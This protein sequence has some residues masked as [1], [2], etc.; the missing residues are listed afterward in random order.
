MCLGGGGR[1]PHPW[2]FWTTS[3]TSTLRSGKS[4]IGGKFRCAKRSVRSSG[5]PPNL[6]P[7]GGVVG[8]VIPDASKPPFS[9]ISRFSGKVGK[10]AFSMPP[11]RAASKK[12]SQGG[13]PPTLNRSFPGLGHFPYPTPIFCPNLTFRRFGRPTYPPIG[14]VVWTSKPTPQTTPK[15]SS[16]WGWFGGRKPVQ[17]VALKTSPNLWSK[18]DPEKRAVSETPKRCPKSPPKPPQTTPPLGG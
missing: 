18:T 17:N 5:Y 15:P 8:G 3:P 4:G 2:R 1:Y 12:I 13:S 7:L 14:G 10:S 11:V 6:P 9:P 16:V